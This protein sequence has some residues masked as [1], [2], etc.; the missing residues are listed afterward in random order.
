MIIDLIIPALN[1]EKAIAVVVQEIPKQLV[2]EVIVVDNNSTDATSARAREAGATVLLCQEPGYGNACLS[3]LAY[4]ANK[5][6]H[7]D[8]I[9]FLDGDHS[10]YPEELPLL[11][12]EIESGAEV[13]IG[14]RALGVSERGSMTVPQR[15]GNWLA[16]V[17]IH[18]LYGV[19]V[20]DLGPFRAI[21]YPTML[22][23]NMGDRNYGWTAELQVK[24]AKKKLNMVEVPVSYR[25][26]IGV[27]KVS[28]T[29]KG[30]ILAGYKIITTILKYSIR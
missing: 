30:S 2:R 21:R 28:G 3:G 6:Q 4:V 8:V 17:M 27:S 24:A 26:R 18:T 10:D 14:S 16:G 25:N 13:V 22:D 19:K 12:Q 15:F 23:L 20:S 5:E 29:V 9:V 1:E 11:L 7:P